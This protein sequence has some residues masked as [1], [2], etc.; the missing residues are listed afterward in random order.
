MSEWTKPLLSRR[1]CLPIM[2]AAM[3]A[4]WMHAGDGAEQPGVVRALGRRF[5]STGPRARHLGRDLHPRD[6][7]TSSPTQ[8]SSSSIRKQPEF[9]E[10]LWQYLNRRVS[11]WRISDRQGE[12][13]GTRRAARAHREGLRRRARHCC[14][15]CGA[16]SRPIGDPIVQKN[17]MRPVFPALAALAW[18]EPRR[19]NYWEQELLNALPIVE[20]GW[21]TPERDARLLGRRHGPHPMDAGGLAQRRHRLR[22]RRPR[23]AVRQARRRARRRPRAISSSA[24]SIAAASTGATRCAP[25][26]SAASDGSRS[27]DGLAEGR[28][29]ARR[30]P[31]VPAAR[32]R[33]R[34]CGCRC[35]AARPS[36]SARTSTRCAAY[37]P[38]MNYTLAIVPSRRP[39]HRRRTARAAVPR[40]RA[41][42]DARRDPGNPDAA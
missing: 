35:R 14:W 32:R 12:G 21:A 4:P 40:R 28:R 34:S 36:C 24:A 19:R 1:A 18:G 20:R 16:S 2:A 9:S 31:A 11:D 22:R 10:K 26:G 13:E 30:R 15:R 39:D 5:P 29:H 25:A 8:R 6:G 7:A 17:H 42:A 38:S 41:P 23:V 3:A 27:Y 33:P 37:N